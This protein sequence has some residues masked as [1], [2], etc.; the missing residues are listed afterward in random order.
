M[1]TRSKQ[2][3]AALIGLLLTAGCGSE[4]SSEPTKLVL[5]GSSTVAPLASE[6]ARRFEAENPGVRIDVQTGGSSR[7]ILDARKGLADIGMVSRGLK[8]EESDL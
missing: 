4:S 8:D 3:A 6:L 5:T 2:F 1:N 7:G